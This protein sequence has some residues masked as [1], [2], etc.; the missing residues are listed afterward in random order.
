MAGGRQQSK[1][2]KPHKP[3]LQEPS[4]LPFFTP[5]RSFITNVRENVLKQITVRVPLNFS[6]E[7]R[8]L[9][10]EVI[11]KVLFKADSLFPTVDEE[12]TEKHKNEKLNI[13]FK[14][15]TKELYDLHENGERIIVFIDPTSIRPLFD[16]IRDTL[17]N[18]SGKR[19]YNPA[20]NSNRR[21]TLNIATQSD[22]YLEV[23][24]RVH[25]A[26]V[27]FGMMPGVVVQCQEQVTE[28]LEEEVT[29]AEKTKVVE[30][31]ESV[32]ANGE[33]ENN[34]AK[35]A[36]SVV[37][38]PFRDFAVVEVAALEDDLMFQHL[39]NGKA[40]LTTPYTYPFE[41]YMKKKPMSKKVEEGEEQEEDPTVVETTK[42]EEEN[43]EVISIP[44][45][46]ML[47]ASP[48]AEFASPGKSVLLFIN[49]GGMH[50]MSV[51]PPP[52]RAWPFYVR[53]Q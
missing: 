22:I 4:T 6:T 1:V 39:Q 33:M 46:K 18:Q 7:K 9:Y 27:G 28:S 37:V 50:L 42:E 16:T 25:T 40:R 53:T 34:T 43:N 30:E 51:R 48:A 12:N 44:K 26:V 47:V 35:P 23:Q 3:S 13:R 31:A 49:P 10:D 38:F 14:K 11:K 21:L 2:K 45:V 41:K 36:K 5:K 29:T 8:I 24:L 19:T 32:S 15:E 20:L 52:T 17:A